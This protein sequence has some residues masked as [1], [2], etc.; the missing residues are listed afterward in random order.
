MPVV[1]LLCLLVS[2]KGNV[3]TRTTERL[4]R[5]D[6]ELLRFARRLSDHEKQKLLELM[7]ILRENSESS[8]FVDEAMRKGKQ[9]LFEIVEFVKRRI[10]GSNLSIVTGGAKRNHSG[11]GMAHRL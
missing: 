9:E 4:S 2:P 10:Y 8:K 6:E 7:V 5:D 3:M 1:A 11:P